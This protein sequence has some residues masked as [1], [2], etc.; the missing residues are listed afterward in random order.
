[1]RVGLVHGNS[2][3]DSVTPVPVLLGCHTH[4][5]CDHPFYGQENCARR[6]AH[7]KRLQVAP[8]LLADLESVSAVLAGIVGNLGM[9]GGIAERT[10]QPAIESLAVAA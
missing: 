7:V 6:L 3:N 2:G 1:M 9:I 4:S 8:A 5:H 10:A